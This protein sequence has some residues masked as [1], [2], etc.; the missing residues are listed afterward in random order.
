MRRIRDR[1]CVGLED[2][3]ADEDSEVD[4]LRREPAGVT[5]WDVD[6][7]RGNEWC[8]RMEGEGLTIV[9]VSSSGTRRASLK[10]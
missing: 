4:V 5:V 1:E 7:R 3:R 10:R 2:S 6:L 9:I 8:A